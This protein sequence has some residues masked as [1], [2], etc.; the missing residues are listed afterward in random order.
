M[1][2]GLFK[3]H[4]LR[5]Q[6]HKDGKEEILQFLEKEIGITFLQ[7]EFILS[8]KN[9]IFTVTS[10]KKSMLLKK[11]VIKLLQEKGYSCRI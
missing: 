7:E 9:I 4:I 3:K 2:E 10:V 11:G 1:D 8:K 6:L 5:I